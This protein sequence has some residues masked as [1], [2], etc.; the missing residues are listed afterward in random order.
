MLDF[1]KLLHTWLTESWP[2]L[3]SLEQ[4]FS[5]LASALTA[6]PCGMSGPTGSGTE[7]SFSCSISVQPDVPNPVGIGCCEGV[8]L[9]AASLSARLVAILVGVR[10]YYPFPFGF[11][12]T[13]QTA[14]HLSLPKETPREKHPS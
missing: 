4:S 7:G 6:K 12:G 13:L 9:D 2:P 3:G 14:S 11:L 8:V 1:N 10:T 5:S